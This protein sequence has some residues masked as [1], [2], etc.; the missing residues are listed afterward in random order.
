MFLEEREERPVDSMNPELP[1]IVKS[2]PSLEPQ[3]LKHFTA[4]F[5]STGCP[6]NSFGS[7]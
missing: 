4:V 3:E 6:E 1:F 2:F 5:L 7:A